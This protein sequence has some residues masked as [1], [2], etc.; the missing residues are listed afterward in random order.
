VI[1]AVAQATDDERAFWTRTIEKGQQQ[2]GDLEQALAL[3]AKYGTLEATR[4][5]ALLW[6]EAATQA[7]T[8]LPEHPIRQMLHDLAEYVV[9]RLH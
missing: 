9:S 1:K 8:P 7:L 2:E 4:Q 6:A 3:M 5:D